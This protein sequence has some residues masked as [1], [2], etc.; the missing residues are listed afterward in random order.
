LALKAVRFAPSGQFLEVSPS[1]T[2]EALD[3]IVGVA[4]KACGATTYLP[5]RF[6]GTLK[7]AGSGW[8]TE[9]EE[10]RHY[11]GASMSEEEPRE[12]SSAPQNQPLQIAGCGFLVNL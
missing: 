3:F 6:D 12:A 4:F 10:F 2:I 9:D 11:L 7:R 8:Q 1:E 5:R